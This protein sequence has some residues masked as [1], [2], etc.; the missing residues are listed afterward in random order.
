M[1]VFSFLSSLAPPLYSFSS[2]IASTLLV[3][4]EKTSRFCSVRRLFVV[5]VF[6]C[7]RGDNKYV[8][9]KNITSIFISL[10]EKRAEAELE[11]ERTYVEKV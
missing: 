7:C 5:F 3:A 1:Q 10:R 4:K 11:P 9:T 8:S 2:L 6:V